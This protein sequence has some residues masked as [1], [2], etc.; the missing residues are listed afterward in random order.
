MA[1]L[2]FKANGRQWKVISLTIRGVCHEPTSL[3]RDKLFIVSSVAKLDRNEP[4]VS[5]FGGSVRIG[6]VDPR[7]YQFVPA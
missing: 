1:P 6:K 7:V 4:T 2:V 3:G 5:L